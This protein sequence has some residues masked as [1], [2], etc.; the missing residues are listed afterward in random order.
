MRSSLTVVPFDCPRTC[1]AA[2]ELRCRFLPILRHLTGIIVDS[3]TARIPT[4]FDYN[5]PRTL[6]AAVEAMGGLWYDFGEHDLFDTKQYGY[7]FRL[8][9]AGGVFTHTDGKTYWG[10][11]LVLR[12]DGEL[13]Y[14]EYGGRWGDVKHLDQL[15]RE[16][17]WVKAKA[18]AQ[19][20]GYSYEQTDTTLTIYHPSGRGRV[21]ITATGNV[22]A[23]EFNGN[24]CHEFIDQLC[25]NAVD[26]AAKPEMFQLPA[27]IAVPNQ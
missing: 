3:H 1:P 25:P 18:A 23:F 9:H 5:D 6:K 20:E 26:L 7:G 13:A 19:I 8:P 27:Q 22:E 2:G 17:V 14:D 4:D 21:E 11:P 24:G 15:K 10:H 16:Y 12:A